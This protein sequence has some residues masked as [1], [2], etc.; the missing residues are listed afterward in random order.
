MLIGCAVDSELCDTRTFFDN[1][2]EPEWSGVRSGKC[3]GIT[4]PWQ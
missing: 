2:V 3:D 1:F 4:E